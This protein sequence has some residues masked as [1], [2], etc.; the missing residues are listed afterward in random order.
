MQARSLKAYMLETEPLVHITGPDKDNISANCLRPGMKGHRS[1][2]PGGLVLQLMDSDP[3]P[4][5][6]CAQANGPG[7]WHI[8]RRWSLSRDR[9]TTRFQSTAV[10]A[11]QVQGHTASPCT[12]TG[13]SSPADFKTVPALTTCRRLVSLTAPSTLDPLGKDCASRST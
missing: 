10:G 6:L 11:P 3:E 7:S 1:S 5:A 2:R 9:D 8:R 12:V 13:G 4:H